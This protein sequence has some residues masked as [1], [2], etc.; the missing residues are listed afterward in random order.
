MK[1]GLVLF[2]L[3]GFAQGASSWRAELAEAKRL[4]GAGESAQAARAYQGIVDHA[5]GLAPFELN[6]LALE[7]FYA[8]RYN[9]SESVYHEALAGWER[10]GNAGARDRIVTA[11]N[12][13]TLLRAE[14]R[15]PEAESLLLD[16]LRQAEG[17][18]GKNSLE[19]A[20]VA[21]GLAAL[22]LVWTEYPKAESFALQAKAVLE[23]SLPAGHTERTNIS[24][25]LGSIYL[26]E[27]HYIE[28]EQLLRS[29]LEFAKPRLAARTYSELAVS[30][31]RQ[32]RLDDAESLEQK[33]LEMDR[34]SGALPS[35]LTA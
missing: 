2:I 26:E 24:S 28:A 8:G 29:T 5:M 20:R 13:G 3:Y 23:Q 21:S 34:Q 32:D 6:D 10:L 35:P 7:L 4:Q 27:G 14:G 15:Y 22:Y 17:M 33:A 19:T 31:L 16:C 12:L 9:E 18:A 11:A 25:L 30:A 1:T